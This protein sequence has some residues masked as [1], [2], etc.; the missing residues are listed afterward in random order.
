MTWR[1]DRRGEKNGRA[2]LSSARVRQMSQDAARFSVAYIADA[3]VIGKFQ[4]YRIIN[5]QSRQNG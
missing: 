2:K 3:Y 4:A 1:N 5:N